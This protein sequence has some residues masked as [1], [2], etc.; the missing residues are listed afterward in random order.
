MLTISKKMQQVVVQYAVYHGRVDIAQ[1]MHATFDLLAYK[2]NLLDFAALNNQTERALRWAT[3][4]HHFAAIQ[5]LSQQ[6]ASVGASMAGDGVQ[7]KSEKQ[8]GQNVTVEVPKP[9]QRRH[10]AK[11]SLASHI[12]GGQSRIK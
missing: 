6:V 4:F 2:D 7:N 5:F 12:G 1:Y 10:V 3:Q 9:A 11:L 8:K